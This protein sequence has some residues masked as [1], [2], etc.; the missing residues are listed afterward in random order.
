MR[1]AADQGSLGSS[2]YR[3]RVPLLALGMGALLAGLWAGLLRLGWPVPLPQALLPAAHGP[4]MVSGF[5]GTLISLE[6]AVALGRRWAY[7]VPGMTGCGALLLICGVPGRGGPWLLA[8]GSLGLVGLFAVIL[9]RQ[10]TFATG[11]M[12]L[13]AVVWLGGNGL[14]LA[15]WPMASAVLWWA[16]FLALTIAG[17]RLELNRLLRLSRHSHLAFAAALSLLLAGLV[18]ASI[19]FDAGMRLTGSGLLML[20]AWLLHYD[21]ARRTV[22]QAGLTRFIAISLLSGYVWLG[23]SGLLAIVYGGVLAGPRYDAILHTLFLGFVVAM[24]F[25]HAPVIFAAVLSLAVPFR[26]AFYAH[27]ALL[28]MSLVLRIVGDLA[29]WW[30][31]RYW[32]GLLNVLTV[33]LFLGNTAGAVW[34]GRRGAR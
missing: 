2:P 8:L 1:S 19:T 20:A 22:R 13:G 23:V 28:H 11:L 10:T 4:L 26:R 24:I 5:L 3:L 14:W 25:G 29:P 34:Q 16:G 6:R 17:E 9:C 18:V 12:G 30:P 32:G 15:G 7:S 27:L 31:G 21:I 33:L